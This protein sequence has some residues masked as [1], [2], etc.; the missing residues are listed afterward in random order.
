MLVTLVEPVFISYE[1]RCSRA[2]DPKRRTS[3]MATDAGVIWGLRGTDAWIV[4]PWEAITDLRPV[5]VAGTLGLGRLEVVTDSATYVFDVADRTY[6]EMVTL[7]DPLLH[8]SE[9]D[10]KWAA[11]PGSLA[12]SIC[13][14]CGAPMS[15]ARFCGSCGVENT[16]AA[17]QPSVEAGVPFSS[18]GISRT[19]APP[20]GTPQPVAT[21]GAQV[22]AGNE[23]SG[24]A[25]ALAPIIGLVAAALFATQVGAGPALGAGLIIYVLVNCLL[26]WWDTVTLKRI[27]ITDAPWVAALVL[28]PYYLYAR[29]KKVQRPQSL[30]ALWTVAFVVFIALQTTVVNAAGGAKGT[31]LS[32]GALEQLIKNKFNTRVPGGIT[33]NCPTEDNVHKG[34]H[35]QCLITANADTSSTLAV[36]V[37]VENNSGYVIFQAAG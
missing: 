24:W 32:S 12:P 27:G 19:T 21:A 26:I 6:A 29:Q 30:V 11:E 20:G 36:N 10:G 7:V 8:P 22:V 3:L 37:T 1:C 34:D 9:S 23:I 17:V 16:P 13:S 14:S 35:F 25:V 33:V 4:I 2:E 15:G 31:N 5:G 18:G 28:M